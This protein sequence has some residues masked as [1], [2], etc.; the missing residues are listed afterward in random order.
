MGAT[1]RPSATML[2]GV[3]NRGQSLDADSGAPE[4]PCPR[5]PARRSF[6]LT[7]TA[8]GPGLGIAAWK[9]AVST[10]RWTGSRQRR[11]RPLTLQPGPPESRGHTPSGDDGCCCLNG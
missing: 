6:L 11:R 5:R 2:L 1:R 4:R 3:P 9:S 10:I 7:P 8:E